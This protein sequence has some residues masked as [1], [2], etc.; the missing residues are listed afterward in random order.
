MSMCS[1]GI[2][3]GVVSYLDKIARARARA[4]AAPQH[5]AVVT[6]SLP[7]LVDTQYE[8]KQVNIEHCQIMFVE[9]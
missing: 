8:F 3:A 6:L 1:I 4:R 7:R 5:C 9:L 2:A